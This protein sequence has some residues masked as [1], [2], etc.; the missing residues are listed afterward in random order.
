MQN[1]PVKGRWWIG[2]VYFAVAATPGTWASVLANVI[3]E[4]GWEEWLAL[5]FMV[6]QIAGMISP[7]IIGA[8]ADRKFPAE[9]VLMATMAASGVLI[10]AAFYALEHAASPWWF[11]ALMMANSLAAAPTWALITT[12]A[13]GNLNG[14]GDNFGSFRVWGTVGWMVAGWAVSAFALDHS[15]KIGYLAAF[16][17]VLGVL[18]CLKLPK[19]LPRGGQMKSWRSVLGLDALVILK[20]RDQAVYFATCFLFYLPISAFYMHTPIQL[21]ELGMRN[22]ATGMTVAQVV[23]VG[24]IL[25][26]GLVMAR[27]RVK[28]MFLVAMF[29]GVLRFVLYAV[30]VSWG[31]TAWVLAGVALHGICWPFFFETGKV[32][33]DRRVDVGMR[34]QAQALLT[35]VSGGLSALTGTFVVDALYELIVRGGNGGWTT[36]WLVLTGMGGLAMLFFALGYR[37][38]PVPARKKD[39]A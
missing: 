32:F 34:A 12:V 2:V 4:R 25:L 23:E 33:V 21:A 27:V 9:K 29:F 18:A 8:W 11:L 15:P 16:W 13:L 26:M 7:L 35:L 3:K 24:A 1:E 31:S 28:T 37:G 30:G 36:Y 39:Q 17:R 10:F 14:K 19:T 6:P 22:V 20:E 38:L 5:A